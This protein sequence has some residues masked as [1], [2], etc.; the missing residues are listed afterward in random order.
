MSP[1]ICSGDKYNYKTDIWMLGCVLYELTC[2]KKPFHGDNFQNLIYSILHSDILPIPKIY[3]EELRKLISQFLKKD[4][5]IRPS[6]EEILED[7]SYAK[8][9]F[10]NSH[11]P[12]EL[13]PIQK[14]TTFN[15]SDCNLN[16]LKYKESNNETTLFI[17]INDNSIDEN[18]FIDENCERK[19]SINSFQN[20]QTLFSR[21]VSDEISPKSSVTKNTKYDCT[22]FTSAVKSNK[23][24][25]LQLND[26]LLLKKHQISTP[27]ISSKDIFPLANEFQL[28]NNSPKS[29]KNLS[30]EESKIDK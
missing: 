29:N 10:L 7:E 30:L 28:D 12:I 1:E 22:L 18:Y 20:L 24:S 16:N 17:D 25:E 15:F 21:R 14:D 27:Q 9:L 26:E 6:L 3:S 19:H 4:P 11:V 8:K 5:N 23:Y 13:S 2:L